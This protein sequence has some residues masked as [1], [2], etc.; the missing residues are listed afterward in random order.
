[1]TFYFL[2]NL[3]NFNSLLLIVCYLN[4]NF[5]QN[6][7]FEADYKTKEVCKLYEAIKHFK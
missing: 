4:I 5:G 6:V 3:Q 7:E 1:M 2:F